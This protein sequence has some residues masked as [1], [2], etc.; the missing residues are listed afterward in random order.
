MFEALDVFSGYITMFS[1]MG[2][3]S[4]EELT[5]LE[6]AEATLSARQLRRRMTNM[7]YKMLPV[8][9][10]SDLREAL[11]AQYDVELN[12]YDYFWLE[13]EYDLLYLDM[14]SYE[15]KA[16]HIHFQARNNHRY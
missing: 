6:L 14:T 15:N 11:F 16:N 9:N 4:D 2:I 8:I 5:E 13:N 7:K 12:I 10:E 1:E 3:L